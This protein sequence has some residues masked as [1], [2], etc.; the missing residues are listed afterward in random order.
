M[1][2]LFYFHYSFCYHVHSY[3]TE[4]KEKRDMWAT[5]VVQ[6]DVGVVET[7]VDVALGILGMVC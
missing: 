3:N 7:Y 1:Y 4:K 6:T 2:H 5:A